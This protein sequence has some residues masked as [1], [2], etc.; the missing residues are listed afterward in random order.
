MRLLLT[1]I[2]TRATFSASINAKNVSRL[3]EVWRLKLPPATSPFGTMTSNPLILG[4]AVY[5]QDMS[6]HVYCLDR[7]TGSLRWKFTHG[8]SNG[9]PERRRRRLGTRVRQ[10]R[11][12]GHRR[13]RI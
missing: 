10:Q 4:D 11:R 1:F 7:K 2:I 12:H 13:A 5:L 8:E 6:S 3:K 9:G